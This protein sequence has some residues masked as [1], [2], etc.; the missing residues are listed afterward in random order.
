M[1]GAVQADQVV[2]AI[3]DA[4]T[5]KLELRVPLVWSM[6]DTT[7]RAEGA[8]HNAHGLPLRLGMQILL[9][10]PWK[11]SVYLMIY[12]SHVRRLDVNGSHRNRTD[13]ERWVRRTHKHRFSETTRTPRLTRPPTSRPCRSKTSE[14][15]TTV[16]FWRRSV[17]SA[18]SRLVVAMRGRLRP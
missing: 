13:G 10:K 8:V 1:H 7:V 3:M 12:G 11:V 15:K 16:R 18:L 17:A 4:P 5:A 14:R 9:D 2:A 6:R